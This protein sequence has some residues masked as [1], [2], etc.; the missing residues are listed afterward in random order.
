VA[1]WA[2]ELSAF[3]REMGF[4]GIINEPV[5]NA[6]ARTPFISHSLWNVAAW[7]AGGG[8][9]VFLQDADALALPTKNLLAILEHLCASFPTVDRITSYCRSRTAARKTVEE[10]QSLRK[11][12]L[13][14]VHI[15][16]ESG[17]ARVLELACKGVTGHVEAG[18]HVVEAGLSLCAYIMPGLGGRELSRE[19]AEESARMLRDVK[20][21]FVRLRTLVVAPSMPLHEHVQSG[22]FVLATD[23]EI[24]REIRLFVEALGDL[25]IEIV[26]DHV[27]NLLEEVAGHLPRDRDAILETIDRYLDLSDK[28]RARFRLGRRCGILGR[29]SDLEEPSAAARVDQAWTQLKLSG[30]EQLEQLLRQTMLNFI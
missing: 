15:G 24:V 10:F 23:D 29:L 30:D 12:G 14:R 2:T 9:F 22:R 5:L 27:L 16:M 17:S 20:P 4:D 28:D 7:L 3:S 6:L 11:A 8:K 26:S 21:Q 18:R 25:E 19:H 13:T 1:L